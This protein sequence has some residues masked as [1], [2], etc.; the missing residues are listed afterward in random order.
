M[1]YEIFHNQQE[2]RFEALSDYIVV[3][4]VNYEREGDIIRVTHT[5]VIPECEGQG[6]AAALT[7]K[8]LNYVDENKLRIIPLCSYTKKYILRHSEYESLLLDET[9]N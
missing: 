7:E 1:E 8:I 3:G 4:A 2:E 5:G 9:D 6:I